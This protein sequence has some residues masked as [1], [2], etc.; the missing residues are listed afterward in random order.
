MKKFKKAPTD[1]PIQNII[2]FK[3]FKTE[4]DVFMMTYKEKGVTKIETLF[5]FCFK[6]LKRY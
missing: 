6:E 1:A 5:C 4:Q 3:E 2:H